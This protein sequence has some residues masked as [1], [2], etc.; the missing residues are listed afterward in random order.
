VPKLIEFTC[1]P[2]ED[3][4]IP[5]S[6]GYSLY[7]A[8]LNQIGNHN[9]KTAN[10]VHESDFS[11]ISV[12]GLNGSFQSSRRKNHKTISSNEEYIFRVG[13][14]DPQEREVF[15]ALISP[16]ILEEK[17]IKLTNGDLKIRQVESH[18]RS[19]KE[20]IDDS[21]KKVSDEVNK[22]KFAF[23]SPTCIQYANSSVTEMFPHRIAV[24]NSIASKWNRVCPQGLEVQNQKGEFGRYLIEKPVPGSYQTHSVLVNRI[25]DENEGHSR[26]IF[27]QG[28]TGECQ[29]SFS[30]QEGRG[31]RE[32]IVT[33]AK[34][35]EYSGVG[36]AV[37][38]GCG[39]VKVKLR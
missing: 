34:F 36:S 16:M 20:L 21:Q 28:F 32:K 25:Y 6:D 18:S 27:R 8:L 24:F 19:F 38:R 26:P 22:M 15:Q 31:F 1:R 17:P 10:E 37:A 23:T 35:S 12:S 39:S 3:F 13:V 2:G 11:S 5:Y 30:G 14:T 4:P 29:Y 33:L 9:R 7:S